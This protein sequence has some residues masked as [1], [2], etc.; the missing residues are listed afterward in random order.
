MK[1]CPD[2]QG[3]I[4]RRGVRVS[5]AEWLGV[6]EGKGGTELL[7]QS[8]M[9]SKSGKESQAGYDTGISYEPLKQG[10]SEPEGEARFKGIEEGS[11]PRVDSPQGQKPVLHKITEFDW[12]LTPVCAGG[13]ALKTVGPSEVLPPGH[14]K[15]KAKL[16]GGCTTVS[17]ERLNPVNGAAFLA[18]APASSKGV[19]RDQKVHSLKYGSRHEPTAK[20]TF[21]PQAFVKVDTKKIVGCTRSGES[22]TVVSWSPLCR[23]PN[24]STCLQDHCFL[25]AAPSLNL[26]SRFNIS[27]PLF[28]TTFLKDKVEALCR[29]GPAALWLKRSALYLVN[30]PSSGDQIDQLRVR[31]SKDAVLLRCFTEE[32]KSAN[33]LDI[34]IAYNVAAARHL[35]AKQTVRSEWPFDR[36][37][38]N[39]D[40]CGMGL[41]TACGRPIF[42]WGTKYMKH[43][44]LERVI[45]IFQILSIASQGRRDRAIKGGAN[46]ATLDRT[47][48]AKS[49]SPQH[50]LGYCILDAL[51]VTA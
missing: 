49:T 41:K 26:S 37:S 19:G 46:A 7:K 9:T 40:N 4:R 20:V 25:L 17:A 11:W 12:S 50:G 39:A 44:H 1:T 5:E 15:L 14:R 31:P 22:G 29:I 48:H 36:L 34:R 32:I 35:G 6:G 3:G 23:P 27:L 33:P 47:V 24:D 38:C 18:S 43:S 42:V 10:R 51:G 13:I 21:L 16:P 2:L 45:R 28:E 8:Q 30:D